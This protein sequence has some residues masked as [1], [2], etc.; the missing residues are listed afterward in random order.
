MM[1]SETGIVRDNADSVK[2]KI[3]KRDCYFKSSSGDCNIHAVVWYP[4]KEEYEKPFGVVQIA[5]GMIDHIERFEALA[6]YLAERGFVVAGNDH[7]GHGDSVKSKDD[8]GY[9][10]PGRN[11][12][13]YLVKDM[14][15][16]TK[17][18]KKKYPD[19]PYTLIGHSMGSYMTRR[20]LMSYGDELSAAVIL[21]T[22]NQSPAVVE[23]GLA[24]VRIA[25]I[26]RGERHRSRL[27]NKMMFGSFN[28]RISSPK[29]S[30][31]WLTRRED[32]VS[33]YKADEK[34][35]YIFTVN[36]YE[37]LLKVIKY[38]IQEKNI[39]KTPK[40]LPLLIASGTED[41]VGDYGR[42]VEKLYEKYKKYLDDVE[43]KL[44]KECRHEL[45]SEINSE[46]I[47]E[48]IYCWLKRHC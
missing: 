48:D 2:R 12:A 38:V 27:L 22:G 8:W 6:L 21:G 19:L 7:L 34:C 16:L 41:P 31:D 10:A 33:E 5:H 18:M 26:F 43:L 15:R 25:R 17:I 40:E 4:D 28:S 36:A 30:S 32:I 14:Y 35:S 47:F 44:Y 37:G 46:E 1:K 39:K 42:A 3:E 45:H 20:Y 9:F 23:G 29:T 13:Q 11:S 24:A